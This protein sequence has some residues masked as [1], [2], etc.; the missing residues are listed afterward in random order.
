MLE[1]EWVGVFVG[2]TETIISVK[3]GLVNK[4]EF[5][6]LISGGTNEIARSVTIT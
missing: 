3:N 5:L 6:G 1:E 2:E 4:V